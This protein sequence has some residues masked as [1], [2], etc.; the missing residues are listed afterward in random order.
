M[1]RAAAG[2]RRG[3]L[4][5]AAIVL[6]NQRAAGATTALVRGLGDAEALVRGACAWAL[7]QIGVA[8]A[9]EALMQRQMVETDEVVR[10]EI[11]MAIG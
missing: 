4:R 1:E 8:D 11:E 2:R 6:G 7:G 9:M 10:R 3:I 5:N